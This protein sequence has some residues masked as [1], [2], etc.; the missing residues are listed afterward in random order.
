MTWKGGEGKD[1]RPGVGILKDGSNS[2]Q[3]ICGKVGGGGLGVFK[4]TGG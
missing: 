1:R 3:W 4:E 2:Q